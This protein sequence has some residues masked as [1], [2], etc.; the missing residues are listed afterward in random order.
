MNDFTKEELEIIYD[1]LWNLM[2]LGWIKTNLQ[3]NKKIQSMIDNYCEHEHMLK[4]QPMLQ[5]SCCHKSW[6]F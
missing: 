3:L 2:K 6:R 5:C 4:T 1:G